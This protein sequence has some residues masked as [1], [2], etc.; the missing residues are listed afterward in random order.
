LSLRHDKLG[1][2]GLSAGYFQP[3]LGRPM[4]KRADWKAGALLMETGA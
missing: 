2:F 1:R 4:K 3:R